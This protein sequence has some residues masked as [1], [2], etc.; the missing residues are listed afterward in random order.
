MMWRLIAIAML[1]GALVGACGDGLSDQEEF[2]RLAEAHLGATFAVTYETTR[3]DPYTNERTTGEQ[4]WYQDG[5]R[6]RVEGESRFGPYVTISRED[7]SYD[8]G[9]Q[10][11][12]G[13]LGCI[14]HPA[15]AVAV[16]HASSPLL[17]AGRP[18]RQFEEYEVEGAGHRTIANE[19]A[20]CFS[21]HGKRPSDLDPVLCLS[22]DGALLLAEIEGERQV[23]AVR[24]E[25]T[26]V[27]SDIPVGIFEPPY[28]I[29]GESPLCERF[30]C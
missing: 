18:L 26:E 30:E 6:G 15:N 23:P 22:S 2:A 20:T 19:D 17:V 16:L 21:L 12:D 4:T 5:E 11:A 10:D 27:S 7:R 8:C 13:T 9:P 29:T 1:A 25:A 14:V 3:V 24:W 28:A